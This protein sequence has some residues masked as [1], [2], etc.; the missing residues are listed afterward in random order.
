MR[1]RS[2]LGLRNGA[3]L[4]EETLAIGLDQVGDGLG[5]GQKG[6]YGLAKGSMKRGA[7]G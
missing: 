4:A 7:D 5:G 3:G 6:R 1:E 2:D